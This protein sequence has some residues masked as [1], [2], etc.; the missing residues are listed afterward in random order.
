VDA[1]MQAVARGMSGAWSEARNSAT[2]AAAAAP[3]AV[4]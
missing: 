2:P 4:A 3:G 1:V